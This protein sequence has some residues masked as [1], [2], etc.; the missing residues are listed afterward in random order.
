MPLPVNVPDL[1]P[2]L[3]SVGRAVSAERLRAVAAAATDPLVLLGLNFLARSGDPVRQELA[4]LAVGQKTD[5]GPITA[6]LTLMLDRVDMDSA[7]EL[8]RKDPGNALGH[9]LLG[10]LVHISNHP[11][12]AREEFRRAAACAEMRFY[13]AMLGEALF[14][15]VDALELQGADRV[16]AL[17]WATSRWADF[18]SFGIQPIYWAMSELARNAAPATRLELAETLLAL[19]GHLFVTNF[20]NR[21]FAL[22]AVEAAFILRAGFETEASPARRNGY[23]A[24]VYGLTSPLISVPGIKE[25][26]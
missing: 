6:L 25:W 10:T 3:E 16:C 13:G 23:A 18:S 24:A 8:V 21:W 22:R 17:S 7:R 4:D 5:Y 19:A 14:K 15:A 26:W 12:E 1:P 9:Y 11:D 2:T 20:T